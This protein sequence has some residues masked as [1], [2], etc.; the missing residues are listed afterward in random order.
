[1]IHIVRPGDTVASI[2]AE[3][4][5]SASRIVFD[6]QIR[7]AAGLVVGQ[8]LLILI[9]EIT[10]QV[11][12]GDTLQQIAYQYGTT[13]LDLVRNNAFL[14]DSASLYAGETLVIRYRREVTGPGYE[15]AKTLGGYLYPF[16]DPYIIQQSMLYLTDMYLFSYGFTTGGQ[17]VIPQQQGNWIAMA[18]SFGVS[19]VLVLTPLTPEG[20]FNSN[21]VTM[22]VNDAQLQ[23]TLI[24]NLLMEMEQEGYE[25][26]DVDFEFIQPADREGY[27]EFIRRLTTQMNAQ[28]YHVSVA[29]APKTSDDQPGVLYAGVDYRA[30]GEI[31]NSVLVMAYEWGYTLH[32]PR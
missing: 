30:L 8:A 9:P 12:V 13:V 28:G 29:L 31:A 26:I 14:L 22:L 23:Q 7:N 21:L 20:T 18:Q 24:D 5:V 10:Y 15:S 3:Y 27:V 1:M 19:P 2:A 32:R 6:N 16:A 4:G 25:A 11:Q 17:L